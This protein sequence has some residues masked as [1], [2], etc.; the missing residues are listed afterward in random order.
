MPLPTN[1]QIQTNDQTP[2]PLPYSTEEIARVCHEANRAYCLALGDDSQ[3]PWAQAADWQRQS[4]I[5]GV[6][7]MTAEMDSPDFDPSMLHESWA[8]EKR[9]GGWVYGPVKDA[10]A[11]THPCLLPFGLLPEDQQRKDYLFAVIVLALASP[12]P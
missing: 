11:K 5:K 9:Q 3:L 7:K 4:A 12:L 8:E 2:N 1:D 6:E 10:T